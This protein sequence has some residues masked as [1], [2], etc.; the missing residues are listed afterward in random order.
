MTK[1]YVETQWME[2]VNKMFV[3]LDEKGWMLIRETLARE[4]PTADFVRV[5]QAVLANVTVRQ[6]RASHFVD[7]ARQ[8]QKGK[9]GDHG[10]VDTF[11]DDPYVAVNDEGEIVFTGT[12][13]EVRDY[14]VQNRPGVYPKS[15]KEIEAGQPEYSEQ[16]LKDM[17]K[18]LVR[19][20]GTAKLQHVGVDPEDWEN[21][22]Q[23][24]DKCYK[25]WMN[26][27]FKFGHQFDAQVANAA[28]PWG[29]DQ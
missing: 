13:A 25:L 1:G 12:A 24:T 17:M 16:D 21:A 8:I 11:W 10:R 29:L 14:I 27:Q 5:C 28:D 2:K 3:P 19:T 20:Y 26:G 15:V 22:A 4:C 7:Q 23:Y 6:L 9:F 18:G